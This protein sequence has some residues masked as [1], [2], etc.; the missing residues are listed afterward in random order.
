LLIRIDFYGFPNYANLESFLAITVVVRNIAGLAEGIAAGGQEGPKTWQ[1]LHFCY[2]KERIFRYIL[3]QIFAC[4]HVLKL[5][6][7]GLVCF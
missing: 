7:S 2:Q 4:K 3:I 5:L 6:Q 1:Y